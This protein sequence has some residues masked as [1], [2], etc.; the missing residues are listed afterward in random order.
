VTK[1]A[2]LESIARAL[3]AGF[4]ETVDPYDI[5]ASLLTFGRAREYEGLSVVIARQEC[6]IMAMRGGIRRKP[7]SVNE[8]CTGCKRC[9]AFGCPAIEF[10]GN[11]ARINALCTG[12]GVCAK[13]CPNNAIEVV[14]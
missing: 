4:V 10:E 1:A 11:S 8:N 3:G 12:C 13:I 6:V 5:D 2:S 9:V 7:F 14:K